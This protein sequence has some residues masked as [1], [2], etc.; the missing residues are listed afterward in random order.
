MCLNVIYPSRLSGMMLVFTIR[1]M[2][3]Y[4][5]AKHYL[6]GFSGRINRAK[7]WLW[8]LIAIL[9]WIVAGAVAAIGFDWSATI[10][11]LKAPVA[12]AVIPHPACKGTASIVAM[13]VIGLIAIVY[14]WALLAIYAKRLHDR[15]R[16]AWWLLAYV[17]LPCILNGYGCH[18]GGALGNVGRSIAGL[19]GLWV[20][21]DLYCLKGTKGANKYGTDPLE[22]NWCD[23]EK[24][25][26][27]CTPRPEA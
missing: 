9:L 22:P 4:M 3:E 14:A 13:V 2:G 27:G 15:N 10:A 6:F 12:D 25:V 8:V 20:F 7:V 11:A 1:A 5:S 19:I 21:I 17:L 16:S 24:P 18:H 23:P 26:K